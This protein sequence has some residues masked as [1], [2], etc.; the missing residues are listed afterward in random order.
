MPTTESVEKTILI[1]YGFIMLFSWMTFC[2][3]SLAFKIRD[4]RFDARRRSFVFL[5]DVFLPMVQ[6]REAARNAQNGNNNGQ[7]LIRSS[8][9]ESLILF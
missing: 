5:S 1:L 3:D 7:L 4:G 9:L 8:Q 6:E 2:R